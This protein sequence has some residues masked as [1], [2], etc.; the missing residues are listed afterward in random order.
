[1]YLCPTGRANGRSLVKRDNTTTMAPRMASLD[2]FFSYKLSEQF[3]FV[4]FHR[5]EHGFLRFE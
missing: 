4:D 5:G 3:T 1:M 2:L